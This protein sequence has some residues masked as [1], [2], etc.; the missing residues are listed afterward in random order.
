[1]RA[2]PARIAHSR[3][4]PRRRRDSGDRGARPEGP[5]PNTLQRLPCRESAVSRERR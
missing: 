3:G 2:A 5:A 1:V 4:T